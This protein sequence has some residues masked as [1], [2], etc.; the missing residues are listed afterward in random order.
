MRLSE[1]KTGEKGVIV[2]V[3]GHGG[4]RKRIVEMGFIRGKTVEVILDAPLMDPVEYK[5]LDYKVSLR[6]AEAELVE[7]VNEKEADA[8]QKNFVS[9]PG[10][11]FAKQPS[12]E[13]IASERVKSIHVALVGNP[14]CGKTC[15]FNIASGSHEHVGN[16]SGVTVD[17]KEGNFSYKGYKIRLVDLPGTYSLSAYTPEELYVR[18]HIVEK[19]PDIILNVVDTT[20]LERNLYLTTQLIDMD[21]P[22]VMALN[23]YDDFE[24]S[25]N[26]LDSNQLGN[27]LGVPTVHTV[28]RTGQGINQLFDTVI[29]VYEG[30]KTVSRHIHVNHGAV[31]EKHI[32]TVE[33]FIRVNPE[34]NNNYSARFLSIKLL[35]SDRQVTDMVKRLPNG[36]EV[37]Q[38]CKNAQ[39]E[40]LLELK[41]DSE[42]ALTDAKY[43]FIQGALRE[44]FVDNKQENN[45]KSTKLIDRIV[46]HRIWGYP[47][48]F[49]LIYLMFSLTFNL[50]A[51]PMGWIEAFVGWLGGLVG[52]N[53][54]DSAFKDLIVDGI[55]GGVGGVIVFLPNILILYACISWMEDTGYMARAAFIMD[56]IMHKMGLHGKSFIP[57]IMGFGCNIPAIMAT[58]TIEDRKCR[59]ITMLIVP[60]MSCSARLPVYIIFIGAF[61]QT[62]A[63]LVLFSLYLLG[64]VMAILFARLM[65]STIVKGESSPFVMELPPYRMP[66]AK[67]VVRHTW[68]K[69]KQY[70]HKMGTVI[71]AASVIIWCLSY[72]PRL[73]EAKASTATNV[74][75]AQKENS[76]IGRIG[77][78]IEPVIRPCG[79]YWKEGVSIV[80]GIG[81]KEIVA[82]TMGVLYS[83]DSVEGNGDDQVFLS[84][85]IRDNSGLTPLSALS[86]LVFVLLYMPCLPAV[87]A[88]RSESGKHRWALFSIIY[89]TCLAWVCS[90]LIFQIGSL[91]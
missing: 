90:M 77:K 86:F 68:E 71:L 25:G 34:P 17:S 13:Q 52:R 15:I 48:F 27:L 18:R 62:H 66:T 20:N 85:L 44:V 26:A 30:G 39:G 73:D 56:K 33:K 1:L 43:G 55:I 23:M 10:L 14:N 74:S 76:Y 91:F 29:N 59:L 80:A 75:E 37:L 7:V 46:T 21:V 3:M 50:G 16:Y 47:I 88:I 51:Y 32:D 72:Y 24:K 61:F 65:G 53:M 22:M 42:S 64:I 89:T 63:A 81:A 12:V 19:V 35:E 67:A 84:Q 36:D 28:G 87:I 5:I 41:E 54:A 70:L 11:E 58:R 6:R 8:M 60:L 82:S 69:G 31:L 40:I 38:A 79:F 9:Q 49:L 57:M 4:F 45:L 83:H 2:K 78:A